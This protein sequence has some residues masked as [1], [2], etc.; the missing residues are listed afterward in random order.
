MQCSYAVTDQR[1]DQRGAINGDISLKGEALE[2]DLF[3]QSEQM[4]RED[5]RTKALLHRFLYVEMKWGL[6]PTASLSAGSEWHCG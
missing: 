2:A 6:N 3:E 4:R 1:N 5:K